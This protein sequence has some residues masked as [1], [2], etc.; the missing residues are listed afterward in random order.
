MKKIISL[1]LAITALVS[2]ASLCSCSQADI[3]LRNK[4]NIYSDLYDMIKNSKNYEGKT[5]AL[6]TECV[7]VYNFS[8]NKVV[9]YSMLEI[10]ESGKNHALYE[11]RTEDGKYPRT[12]SVVTVIGTVHED[13]YIEVD[14][15][16]NA[17]YSMDFDVDTLE[18]TPNQLTDFI[19][20]YRKQ[21][22][23]SEYYG[24][25]VRIFGH[26][27]TV[28]DGYTF[29]V[30]LDENGKYVWD[31]ELRGGNGSFEYPNTE[32]DTVNPVEIIGTL[33]TFTD[34]N[35]IYTCILVEQIGKSESVF[36]E[37]IVIK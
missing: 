3:D 37:D 11:I 28:E 13:V 16:R 25:T 4:D 6:T 10:D 23:D 15:F 1:I 27:K 33:S 14:K 32:G 17:E 29:L 24:K 36:R 21:Y 19:K 26:L 12:G 5:V 22:E 20:N 8:T 31:I 18:F 35:V 2:L 7:A 34:K 9:R 30:G